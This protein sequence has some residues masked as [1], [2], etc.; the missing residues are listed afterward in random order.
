MI[1]PQNLTFAKSL[2]LQLH[3]PIQLTKWWT[4]TAGGTFSGRSFEVTHTEVPKSHQYITA[5]LY[6]NQ[7][8]VLPQDFSIEISGFYNA[9]HYNGSARNEGFGM[10][11]LGVKKEFEKNSSLQFTITD[12][13]QTM[14][15]QFLY[16]GLTQEAW[17]SYAD[18][19]YIPESGRNRIFKL[20]YFKSFGSTKV[21]AAKNKNRGSQEE[22]SRVSQ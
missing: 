13:F 12:V 14:K 10:M 19:E 11:N 18:G 22:R 21:R 7:E 1:S 3:I 17:G 2:G 16:G 6:G 8:I 15:V 9:P 4:F 20:T 5:N